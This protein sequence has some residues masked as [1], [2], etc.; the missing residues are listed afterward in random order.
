MTFLSFVFLASLHGFGSTVLGLFRVPQSLLRCAAA[1]LVG[2]AFASLLFFVTLVYGLDIYRSFG[3]VLIFVGV[4]AVYSWGSIVY[5]REIK[6]LLVTVLPRNRTEQTVFFLIA[7]LLSFVIVMNYFWSHTDWDAITLYDYRAHVLLEVGFLRPLFKTIQDIYLLSYPWHT[8]ILFLQQYILGAWNGMAMF[9]LLLVSMLFT[10]FSL[11]ESTMGRFHAYI[12]SLALL[13]VPLIFAHTMI[14]YT[15]FPYMV[16][17]GLGV[18]CLLSWIS[19]RRFENVAVGSLLIAGSMW[20]RQSE[21]FWLIAVLL[22]LYGCVTLLQWK[23]SLWLLPIVGVW[24]GWNLYVHGILKQVLPPTS[25]ELTTYEKG[26]SMMSSLSTL[27]DLHRWGSVL[28][29]LVRYAVPIWGPWVLFFIL[30]LL[31][32]RRSKDQLPLIFSV[33]A[34]VGAIVLGTY[35]FANNTYWSEIVDSFQRLLLFAFPVF[36]YSTFN[37]IKSPKNTYVKK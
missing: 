36:I 12:A 30:L 9:S 1:Y 19:S 17:W 13:S 25:A 21:P 4:G 3:L 31:S 29:H 16:Y 18:C 24:R 2:S 14:A 8:S 26:G 28:E 20:I 32:Q 7:A 37:V 11:I 34:S 27:L 6:Q 15:N 10:F 5:W 22:L 33:L 35:L 23:A